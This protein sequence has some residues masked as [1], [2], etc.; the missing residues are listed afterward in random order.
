ML[1]NPLVLFN[2][3]MLGVTTLQALRLEI[4]SQTQLDSHK[5]WL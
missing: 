5:A 4:R 2:T 3:S 1:F